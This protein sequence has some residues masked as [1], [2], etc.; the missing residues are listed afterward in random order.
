M[1]IPRQ[2]T[3]TVLIDGIDIT[4]DISGDIISLTYTDVES[5]EADTISL[6]VHDRDGKWIGPWYPEIGTPIQAKI[7]VTNWNTGEPELDCGEFKIDACVPSGPPD[8]FTIKAGSIPISSNLKREEKTRS[9]EDTTLEKIAQ[10]IAG[11]AGMELVYE[12]KSEIQLDRIDQQQQSDMSLLLSI[13][14]KYGVALKANNNELVLF[15]ESV[16]EQKDA[17]VTISKKYSD[18]LDYSFSHDVSETVS[19]AENSYKDPKS[20]RL[21]QA[22]FKPPK[23]PKTGQKL[24]LNQRPGDLRGDAFRDITV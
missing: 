8:V 16:F 20:G 6:S 19:E 1:P 9:W 22:S 11:D 24:K 10:D 12:V 18:Y 14:H 23:P 13:C 2:A 4:N 17:V 3:V 15:E 7:K 21:A 5:G